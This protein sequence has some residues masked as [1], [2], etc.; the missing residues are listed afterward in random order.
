MPKL[1]KSIGGPTP[2]LEM[3]FFTKCSYMPHKLIRD[4]S[5]HGVHNNYFIH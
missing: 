5:L 2:E 3:E 1:Y 4:K